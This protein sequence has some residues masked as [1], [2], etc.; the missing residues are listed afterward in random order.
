MFQEINKQ[1]DI[2]CLFDVGR[3]VYIF[4]VLQALPHRRAAFTIRRVSRKLGPHS[5]WDHIL[6]RYSSQT[7]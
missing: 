6:K 2:S 1:P 4:Y 3:E 7:M 5:P